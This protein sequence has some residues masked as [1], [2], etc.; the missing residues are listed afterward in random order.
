MIFVLNFA[1][2]SALTAGAQVKTQNTTPGVAHS[3]APAGTPAASKDRD[4]G[5]ARAAD[6]GK[7]K[8]KSTRKSKKGKKATTNPAAKK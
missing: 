8:K 1:L 7:G 2:L 5:T 6:V 3:N 4:T